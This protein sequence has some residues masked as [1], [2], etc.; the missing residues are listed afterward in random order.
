MTRTLRLIDLE[1]LAGDAFDRHDIAAGRLAMWMDLVW[2]HGDLVTVV[3]NA[4]LWR[5]SAWNI[6]IPHRFIVPAL[7]R[8]GAD[9]ALLTAAAD[10]PISAFDRLVIASGD[11]VFTGLAASAAADGVRVSVIANRGSIA[12]SLELAAND[13]VVLPA[14][15][16]G[17]LAA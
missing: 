3:S 10:L 16:R 12:R 11:H 8:D 9:Q 14:A 15:I 17:G 2:T 13:L 7:G 5:R 1:N 4:R 6:G